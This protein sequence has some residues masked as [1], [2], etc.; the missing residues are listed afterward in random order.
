MEAANLGM[1]SASNS[2][3]FLCDIQEKF[4]NAM[5]H[6]DDV[7]TSAKILVKNINFSLTIV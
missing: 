6:F 5:I 3:F 2:V 7:V 1:L 4:K